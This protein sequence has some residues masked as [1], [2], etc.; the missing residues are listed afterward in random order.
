MDMTRAMRN[1]RLLKAVTG[2]ALQEFEALWPGF[3]KGYW[4]SLYQKARKRAPG[5]GQQG[6]L[7]SIRRRLFFLLDYLKV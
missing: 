2:I 1:G 7:N 6:V 4:E 5:G 3:K